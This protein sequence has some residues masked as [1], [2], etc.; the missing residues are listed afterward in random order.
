MINSDVLASDFKKYSYLASWV[1]I[2]LVFST[3]NLSPK[4]WSTS[5]V[6]VISWWKIGRWAA[7]GLPP[8]QING[9]LCEDEVALSASMWGLNQN[10]RY[11]IWSSYLHSSPNRY[12][13][14]Y[15]FSIESDCVLT[16]PVPP[17]WPPG[18]FPEIP[19]PGLSGQETPARPGRPTGPRRRW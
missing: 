11:S 10:K 18:R 17:I 4:N 14:F 13:K 19:D 5:Y 15:L 7:S 9:E 6:W 1:V 3:T 12:R 8:E 16:W 2:V